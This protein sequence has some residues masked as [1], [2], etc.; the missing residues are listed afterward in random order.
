M[1]I[2][3]NQNFVKEECATFSIMPWQLKTQ[4]NILTEII[5]ANGAVPI[6]IDKHF[7][8]IKQNAELLKFNLPGYFTPDFLSTQIKGLLTR[9]KLFQAANAQLTV[10]RNVESDDTEIIITSQF[11]GTGIYEQNAKGLLIDIYNDAFVTVHRPS[12]LDQHC[13]LA[14]VMAKIAARKKNLDDM[15][16]MADQGFVV[17]ATDSIFF[18][19]QKGK[20]MTPPLELGVHRDIMREVII[21]AAKSCKYQIDSEAFIMSEDLNEVDEIFLGSTEKGLQWVSG[22]KK[23]RYL[24]KESKKLNDSVNNILFSPKR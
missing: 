21:E 16:L 2:S 18:A 23:H 10:V 14:N 6:L 4:G 12:Q 5:R 17:S 22:L 1:Y 13:Q 20:I 8:L 19:I 3:I 15:L 11:A 7:E 24:H 9:N